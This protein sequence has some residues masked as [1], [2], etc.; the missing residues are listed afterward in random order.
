MKIN[1]KI[2][3][4]VNQDK[5][6]IE[7]R[8]DASCI[9]FLKVVLTP[10]Q[11]SSALSRLMYTPC[12]SVELTDDIKNV[13]KTMEHK[14]I[15]IEIPRVFDRSLDTAMLADM[16]QIEVDKEQEGWI[17]SDTFVSQNS[18]FTKDGKNMA[19]CKVRRWV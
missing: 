1:G 14:T 12:E 6:T 11:L 4:L 5:T 15:E 9:T 13:G 8:D 17:V 2:T 7:V 3:I 19:R 10:E 18:F 16:A